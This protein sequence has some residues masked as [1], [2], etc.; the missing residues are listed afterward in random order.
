MIFAPEYIAGITT[1]A[2]RGSISHNFRYKVDYVMIDPDA[3]GSGLFSRNQ[4]NLASVYDCDHGGPLG[5]GRGVTWARD[6]LAKNGCP[7]ANLDL[8]LLTQPRFFGSVFNPVSFWLAMNGG[9]LI[10]VIA[11]VSTPFGHR[12][13]YLCNQIGFA[14]ITDVTKIIKPK[15]LHVSPFQDVEGDYAF[16]FDIRADQIGIRIVHRNHDDGVIATLSGPR[17]PLT[18]AALIKACLRRPI[19]GL[20]TTALIYWQALRLKLKGARYRS[21]PIPPSDE[22]S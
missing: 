17:A 3:L 18:N 14:P 8:R 9:D 13:S 4:R 12:H 21:T 6:I 11:E 7:P 2:R 20:R 15:T 22:V 16:G 19:G 10:A 1:H 5:A